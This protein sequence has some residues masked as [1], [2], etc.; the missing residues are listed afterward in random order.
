MKPRVPLLSPLLRSDTQGRLLAQLFAHPERDFAV[1]ELA[2]LAQATLPTALRDVDRLVEAGYLTE[3]R[4]GRNRM[5][6]ANAAHP[7]FVPLS[8]IVIYGYGPTA[9]LPDLLRD[10]PG[11]DAAYIFGS[12]AARLEG[13][14]GADPNDI[15]L[16]IVGDTEPSQF[17]DLAREATQALG[18]EVN[19]NV[20][21]P[22]RWNRADDGFIQTVKTRPLIELELRAS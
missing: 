5:V 7:L 3:R 4:M 8:Q 18:R 19:I 1:S 22:S 21:T 12:W 14:P 20:V 17:Y 10:V 16:L 15:D 6:R 2:R 13:Q 9:V 11:I